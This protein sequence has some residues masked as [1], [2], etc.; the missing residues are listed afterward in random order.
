MDSLVKS[1]EMT[2]RSHTLPWWL[3]AAGVKTTENKIPWPQAPLVAQSPYLST[4]FREKTRSIL[5]V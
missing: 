3:E 1:R 2:G 4:S 5:G